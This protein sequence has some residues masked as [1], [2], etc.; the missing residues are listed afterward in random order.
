MTKVDRAEYTFIYIYLLY[1]STGED[2]VGYNKYYIL[3]CLSSR[4]PVL[5][6][7]LVKHTARQHVRKK[8]LSLQY[9]MCYIRYYEYDTVQYGL[10]V[11][12][13]YHLAIIAS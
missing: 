4:A 2:G 10:Q 13:S 1:R 3:A 6:P 11:Q 5:P 12:E 9:A 8:I 7:S